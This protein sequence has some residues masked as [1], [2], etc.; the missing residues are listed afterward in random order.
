M[1]KNSD[2]KASIVM[3]ES[4]AGVFSV[5]WKS[6]G[7]P[8]GE[9]PLTVVGSNRDS[10]NVV[11]NFKDAKGVLY[12]MK[13][14]WEEETKSVLMEMVPVDKVANNAWFTQSRQLLD[15]GN[16][17]LTLTR[18]HFTDNASCSTTILLKKV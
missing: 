5:G 3:K 15:N 7:V 18:T 4:P 14:W 8:S 13:L 10:A 16:L 11:E 17:F 12:T 2:Y 9:V 6:T 1:M